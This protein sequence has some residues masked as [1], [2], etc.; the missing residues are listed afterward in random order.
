MVD[1]NQKDWFE[2]NKPYY[3]SFGFGTPLSD[4]STV[5]K[6]IG[7]KDVLICCSTSVKRRSKGKILQASYLLGAISEVVAAES[8]S[9]YVI[10]RAYPKDIY[11]GYDSEFA[12]SLRETIR[13]SKSQVVLIL[14]GLKSERGDVVQICTHGGMYCHGSVLESLTYVLEKYNMDYAVDKD[15]FTH[16][17]SFFNEFVE[18]FPNINFIE[19]GI[20]RVY[21]NIECAENCNEFSDMLVDFVNYV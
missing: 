20:P 9:S 16:G 21:R 3:D 19:I 12:I 18:E 7:L 4:G 14:M 10:R 11:L 13:Q 8:N 6:G 5:L 1:L 15:L 2:A 17:S